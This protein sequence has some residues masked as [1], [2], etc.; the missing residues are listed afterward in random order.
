MHAQCMPSDLN[1]TRNQIIE[2][3]VLERK[4]WFEW[5]DSIGD[6]PTVK[7]MIKESKKQK[8]AKENRLEKETIIFRKNIKDCFMGRYLDPEGEDWINPWAKDGPSFDDVNHIVR[9]V[10][11]PYLLAMLDLPDKGNSLENWASIGLA[12]ADAMTNTFDIVNKTENREKRGRKKTTSIDYI[13][14]EWLHFLREYIFDNSSEQNLYSRTY[15]LKQI[16]QAYVYAC[17]NPSHHEYA[18][19]FDRME[20]KLKICGKSLDSLYVS[21]NRG[22]KER[23][24]LWEY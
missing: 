10:Q 8:A 21:F 12:K 22:E 9:K 4:N 2:L 11:E 7:E 5:L 24:D 17:K 1:E 6:R 3:I 14:A 18:A 13:R 20:S 19:Y 16:I 23:E 15:P